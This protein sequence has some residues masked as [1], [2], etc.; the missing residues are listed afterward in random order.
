MSYSKNRKEV[1]QDQLDEYGYTFCQRCGTS[2]AFKFDIH[3]IAMK[4]EVP[5][6]PEMHNKRNLI[7]VCRKCHNKFHGDKSIR[8]GIVK[9]R[10]LEKLFNIKL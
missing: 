4:S 8:D 5:N 2:N 3:H 6:H 9:E 1:I 10:G 7:I